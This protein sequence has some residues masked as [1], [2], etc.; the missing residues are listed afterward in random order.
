ML[1]TSAKGNEHVST[2]QPICDKRAKRRG[3][4]DAKSIFIAIS[5]PPPLIGGTNSNESN[6][7]H[8]YLIK[9]ELQIYP[10]NFTIF[11]NRKIV[12]PVRMHPI[13]R[14]G[15]KKQRS[16]YVFERVNGYVIR[17]CILRYRNRCGLPSGNSDCASCH[18]NPASPYSR[19]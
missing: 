10:V 7:S 12:R 8:Q 3:E 19:R 6:L 17:M 1:F 4:P 16:V 2:S 11:R 15:S 13:S 9:V 18:S 14:K 5:I